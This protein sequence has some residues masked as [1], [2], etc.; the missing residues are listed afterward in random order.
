MLAIE[1]AAAGSGLRT[2]ARNR[3]RTNAASSMEI[4]PC[5][6]IAGLGQ[7]LSKLS[8]AFMRNSAAASD[9]QCCLRLTSRFYRGLRRNGVV[10]L[11]PVEPDRKPSTSR[12]DQPDDVGQ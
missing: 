11:L 5:H 4:R 2:V 1:S 9:S 10:A 3:I 6:V 7:R 8:D 12:F